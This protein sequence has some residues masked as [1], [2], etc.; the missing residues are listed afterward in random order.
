MS[1]EQGSEDGTRAGSAPDTELSQEMCL[2]YEF[3]I[4][5]NDRCDKARITKAPEKTVQEKQK[6]LSLKKDKKAQSKAMEWSAELDGE[7]KLNCENV[8]VQRLFL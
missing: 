7:T 6:Y 4:T 8:H 5:R 1:T 2:K 3:K